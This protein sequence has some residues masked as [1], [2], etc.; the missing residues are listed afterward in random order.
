M[1][2]AASGSSFNTAYEKYLPMS[3]GNLILVKIHG[4]EPII[5]VD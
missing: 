1:I 3:K 2:A 5:D 4:G